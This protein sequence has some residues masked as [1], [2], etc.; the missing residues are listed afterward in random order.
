MKM[1]DI[2][3]LIV[4]FFV[5]YSIV[6]SIFGKKKTQKSETQRRT[7]V[8]YQ[9]KDSGKV[10]S[11]KQ[12]SSADVLEELF[13]FKIPKTEN[14]YRTANYDREGINLEKVSWNPE[15][16]F[17]KKV[18]A[19]EAYEKRNIEKRV[20][21]I[22]YDKLVSLESARKKTAVDHHKIYA[23][24][25]DANKKAEEI[26]RRLKSK[27]TVKE[28]FILSELLNKPKALRKIG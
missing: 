20:P 25:S 1:D 11:R 18:S 9:T 27:S 6:A 5:I 14:E 28:A 10:Y 23:R 17:E 22:D 8:P 13:G 2:I 4:F 21:D 26:K 7:Q 12:T 15:K 19:R 3:Q 16:E 24:Q